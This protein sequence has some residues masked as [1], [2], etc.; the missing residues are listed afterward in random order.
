MTTSSPKSK[1][2]PQKNSSPTKREKEKDVTSS[3]SSKQNKLSNS[4]PAPVTRPSAE[5]LVD[6]ERELQKLIAR[7]IQ[8]DTNLVKIESRLYDLETEYLTETQ[9]FGN[10][11]HGV[12]GYLG[13]PAAVPAN[14]SSL[15]RG[16]PFNNSTSSLYTMASQSSVSINSQ[17][18]L[19]SSTSTSFQKS[20]AL[21]GRV[22]EAIANGYAPPSATE[23]SADLTSINGLRSKNHNGENNKKTTSPTKKSSSSKPSISTNSS[24]AVNKNKKTRTETA[25]WQPPSMKSS[26]KK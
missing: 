26:R 14:N 7:K 8:A 23:T 17:Q 9:S 3:P 20:L 10:L 25:E 5:D 4:T 2:S 18:R 15:R 21:I 19:F 6:L 16:A 1:Q 24:A 11:I 13:L 22:P 12:E